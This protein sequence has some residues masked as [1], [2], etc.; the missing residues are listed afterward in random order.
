MT[1]LMILYVYNNSSEDELLKL[2]EE[3][4]GITSIDITNNTKYIEK[5]RVRGVIELPKFIIYFGDETK[6][7]D[8]TYDNYIKIKNKIDQLIEFK[9]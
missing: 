1:E 7:Y 8:G 2:V 4:Q 9:R 5:L 6:V 3:T